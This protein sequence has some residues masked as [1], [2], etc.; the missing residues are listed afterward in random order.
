MTVK[1][2]ELAEIIRN[3]E[4]GYVVYPPSIG[5]HNFDE[6]VQYALDASEVN[7]GEHFSVECC[8]TEKVLFRCQAG[9]ELD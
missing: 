4:N 6:A 9:Q 2:P 5:M 3:N 8:D 7:E 1:Q